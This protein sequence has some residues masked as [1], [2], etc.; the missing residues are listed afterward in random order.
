[1][2][3]SLNPAA[4]KSKDENTESEREQQLF[5]AAQKNERRAGE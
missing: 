2:K 4:Q 1:V 5:I 3:Y